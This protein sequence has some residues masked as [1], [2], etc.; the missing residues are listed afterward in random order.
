MALWLCVLGYNREV[1]LCSLAISFETSSKTRHYVC[2]CVVYTP[3]LRICPLFWVPSEVMDLIK[4]T[5]KSSR[6]FNTSSVEGR[7]DYDEVSI[8]AFL[9][10]SSKSVLYTLATPVR[11][12]F[13]MAAIVIIIFA[14]CRW[15]FRTAWF[16]TERRGKKS[17]TT[18]FIDFFM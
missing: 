15:Q 8:I 17:D 9:K 4:S 14:R 11:P 3:L 7:D 10:K 12:K 16:E 6:I 2:E 18:H 1:S 13:K 5:E